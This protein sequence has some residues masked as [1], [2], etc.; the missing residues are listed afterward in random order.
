VNSFPTT[1]QKPIEHITCLISLNNGFPDPHLTLIGEDDQKSTPADSG[2]KL[3][4]WCNSNKERRFIVIDARTGMVHN[5]IPCIG[6]RVLCAVIVGQRVWLGTE[7]LQIEVFGRHC[8][9]I[10][11]VLWA[12]GTKDAV[13]DLLVDTNENE[14]PKRVFASLAN[15]T[16]VVFQHTPCNSAS[17]ANIASNGNE[18]KDMAVE[19]EKSEWRE[20]AVINLA[21]GTK[22]AKSM[23]FTK[24]GKELWTASGNSIAIID[25]QNLQLIQQIR[26]FSLARQMV[27][28]LVTDGNRVWSIDRKSSIVYQ[29][30]VET[31]TKQFKFDCD[32]ACN[33]K[34]MILAQAV[35]DSLF[36]ESSD[37][38]PISRKI[39]HKPVAIAE[40]DGSE[41][42]VKEEDPPAKPGTPSI[43]LLKIS[44]LLIKATRKAHLQPSVLFTPKKRK[45]GKIIRK[46]HAENESLSQVRPRAGAYSNTSLH[47]GPIL[48]VDDTLWIGRGEGDILVINV[49]GPTSKQLTTNVG[50]AKK[51]KN[52][53]AIFGEVLCHLEDEQG[54]QTNYVKDIVQL[55]KCGR[56]EVVSAMRF[57]SKQNRN[58]EQ[59]N[60][61]GGLQREPSQEKVADNFKLLMFE[62]WRT[63]DF[64]RFSQNLAALHALED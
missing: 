39:E 18:D 43:N 37:S 44:P 21:N 28:Q 47:I 34:G 61:G 17:Y 45:L 64:E 27:T 25:A 8:W 35:S 59:Y 52:D 3:L 6:R 5:D 22:P 12:Y 16:V 62:A 29:W 23:V 31:R 48:M 57:E 58:R 26:V 53:P 40:K 30:D 54:K 51:K 46:I 36:E 19:M 14:E 55:R 4:L 50:Y 24:N 15:G 56:N 10:P 20:A 11:K 49:R 13:M 1:N 9:Q 32:L 63:S 33:V 2:D 60:T 38:P 41:M 42:A 7:G